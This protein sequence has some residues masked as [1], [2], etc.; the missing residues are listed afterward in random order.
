MNHEFTIV[1]YDMVLANALF[2]ISSRSS[3]RCTGKSAELCTATGVEPR[4]CTTL[5][6]PV[7]GNEMFHQIKGAAQSYADVHQAG[8]AVFVVRFCCSRHSVRQSSI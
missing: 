7:D 2:R 8:L 5:V 3:G 1:V 6:S 4:R